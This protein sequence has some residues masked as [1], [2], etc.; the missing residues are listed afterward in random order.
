MT[1]Y[2]YNIDLLLD[3]FDAIAKNDGK[4]LAGIVRAENAPSLRG[5]I[6][7]FIRHGLAIQYRFGYREV[8]LSSKGYEVMELMKQ[9]KMRL[10]NDE[11]ADKEHTVES[12]DGH[13]EV[14]G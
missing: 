14:I 5:R 11:G 1:F 13:G 12:D 9:L 2:L 6:D 10:E 3:T 7:E 8:H 4:N